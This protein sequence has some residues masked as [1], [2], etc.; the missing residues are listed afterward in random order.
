MIL[1]PVAVC[2]DTKSVGGVPRVRAGSVAAEA[3]EEDLA[4][5]LSGHGS[6][7]I[8]RERDCPGAGKARLR[9]RR[10]SLPHRR[11]T[12]WKMVSTYEPTRMLTNLPA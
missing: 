3:V 12:N 1:N 11:G 9:Y 2:E 10:L 5:V 7:A 6:D 8:L 4:G